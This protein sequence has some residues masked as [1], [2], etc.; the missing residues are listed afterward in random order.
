ML[1]FAK[2]KNQLLY[3]GTYMKDALYCL[4]QNALKVGA[5]IDYAFLAHIEPSYSTRRLEIHKFDMPPMLVEFFIIKTESGKLKY[6][7]NVP[8]CLPF[9][10]VSME[11]GHHSYL[12]EGSSRICYNYNPITLCNTFKA[13]CK[14]V[15]Q[16]DPI[17][18]RICN[19]L[20]AAY[21]RMYA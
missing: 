13:L 18:C 15:H 12:S 19:E 5:I 3:D 20:N 14:E 4:V 2:F 17:T 6:V 1:S 8:N 9:Q 21:N 10:T 16:K 7:S 11:S